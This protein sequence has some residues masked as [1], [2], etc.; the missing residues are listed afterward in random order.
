VC[1]SMAFARTLRGFTARR[2]AEPDAAGEA[3]WRSILVIGFLGFLLA[4]ALRSLVEAPGEKMLRA[5]YEQ[6]VRIHDKRR[7][8][9]SGNPA[10]RAPRRSR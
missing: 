7:T 1:S 5:E 9:R 10:R 3:S 8:T 4:Y 2:E 6:A